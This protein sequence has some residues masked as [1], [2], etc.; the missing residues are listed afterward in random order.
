HTVKNLAMSIAIEAAEIMELLQWF[1][2]EEATEQIQTNP[3]LKSRLEEELA[4]VLIYCLSLSI[5]ANIDL[6]QIIRNKLAENE[7]RFPVDVVSGRLGPYK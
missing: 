2:S 6:N 3:D 1:T 7:A 4:D 5:T